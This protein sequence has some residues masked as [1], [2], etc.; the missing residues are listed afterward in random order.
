MAAV[1]EL[2]LTAARL[3]KLAGSGR[4]VVV[5]DMSQHLA[6][7][8]RRAARQCQSAE[9][10]P[11]NCMALQGVQQV[12]ESI[13]ALLAFPARVAE[14]VRRCLAAPEETFVNSSPWLADLMS[15]EA[16]RLSHGARVHLPNQSGL[17]EPSE[18]ALITRSDDELPLQ[19]LDCVVNGLRGHRGNL[20]RLERRKARRSVWRC[21]WSNA[22]AWRRAGHVGF[23]GSAQLLLI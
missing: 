15:R 16:H 10:S 4:E 14:L 18:V 5:T 11:P 21:A 22:S 8:C 2:D 20:D 9:C 6:P 23:H 17:H 12:T 13:A 19:C 1:Q 7:H 3:A